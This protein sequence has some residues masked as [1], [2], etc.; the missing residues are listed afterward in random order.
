MRKSTFKKSLGAS[1]TLEMG[2]A[3]SEIIRDL[4]GFTQD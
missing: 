4:T 3:P 1:W 2:L